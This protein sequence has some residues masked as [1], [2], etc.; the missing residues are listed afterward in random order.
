MADEWLASIVVGVVDLGSA[1]LKV[2]GQVIG[3]FIKIFDDVF[4]GIR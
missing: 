3:I 1:I 2:F 4:K